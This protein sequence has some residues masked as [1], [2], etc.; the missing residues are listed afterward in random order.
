MATKKPIIAQK[1]GYRLDFDL[2][3]FVNHIQIKN[4]LDEPLTLQV[5]FSFRDNYIEIVISKLDIDDN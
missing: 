5:L 4:E 1:K 2:Y 3:Q